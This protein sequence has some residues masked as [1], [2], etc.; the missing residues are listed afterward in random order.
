[1]KEEIIR[2][3]NGVKYQAQTQLLKDVTLRIYRR[4]LCGLIF[5]ALSEGSALLDILKGN[6]RLDK[7]R[8][9][10]NEARRGLEEGA[11]LFKQNVFA[12]QYGWQLSDELTVEDA[13]LMT[14]DRFIKSGNI[15]TREIS[16][17]FEAFQI[18]IPFRQKLSGLSYLR[19]L[20]LQL[21]MAYR[22]DFKIIIL[23]NLA[24]FLNE[25]DMERIM[26]LVALMKQKGAAFI[27]VDNDESV[28]PRYADNI[29]LMRNGRTVHIL[30]R[31]EF[32]TG[33]ISSRL[34]GSKG[35]SGTGGFQINKQPSRQ[36]WVLELAQV[37]AEGLKPVSFGIGKSEKV[38]FLDKEGYFGERL[39]RLLQG[40][41]KLQG[42]EIYLNS[43]PYR[44]KDSS[45]ATKKGVCVIG[46]NPILPGGCLFHNLSGMDNLLLPLYI[47]NSG[48]LIRKQHEASIIKEARDYFTEEQLLSTVYSLDPLVRQKLAYYKWY[49]YYPHLVV[50][51]KPFSGTV[52]NMRR[53][54]EEIIQKYIERGISV[55]IITPNISEACAF[56]GRI[57]SLDSES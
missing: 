57:I 55:L 54:T 32:R 48:A 8:L 14:G 24:S 3:E 25:Q 38:V 4:E 20:Q 18:S 2:I 1:M 36:P 30:S 53:F 9:Y 13:F 26:E 29:S 46:E 31:E 11:S 21:V 39:V 50:C 5:D 43:S 49:L 33:S 56:G 37:K 12:P 40:K 44:P 17:V 27:M 42:G 52:Y 47:K 10:F 41:E 51:V 45:D 22:Q 35:P 16:Y 34:L 15:L 7:G 28:L 19:Q 23:E 6:Q